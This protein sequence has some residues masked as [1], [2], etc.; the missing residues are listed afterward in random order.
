MLDG[1]RGGRLRV[2]ANV[3]VGYDNI[4]V[5]RRAPSTASS[6][7]NTPGVLDETTADLAFLLIL[8][9][10]RLA[11]R[12]RGRPARRPLAR[13]GGSR[14]T[15]AATCTARRSASSATAASARR[16]RGAPTGFGMRVLHH[17]R[18]RHRRCRATSPTSTSCSASAD[19]VSLHVPGGDATRH[20]IDARRLALMKPTAVLVNTARGPVVDE[21]ALADALA[22]RARCSRPGSTSS[23]ASPRCTRGCSPR[24]AHRAAAAHR[25]RHRWRPARAWPRSRA[26]ASSPCSRANART[27]PSQEV[28]MRQVVT[29]QT[30]SG[31]SVF[32]SDDQIEP[33]RLSLMPG[34]DS[35]GCGA[36]TRRRHCPPTARPRVRPPSSPR[37][38]LPLRLRHDPAQ[39][40]GDAARGPRRGGRLSP[41]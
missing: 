30:G 15:S 12:R 19:I 5:A 9:A 2:V 37:A 11:S 38:R 16:S 35:L 21:A 7:C 39:G 8:A 25:Q 24:A 10:S 28:E 13:A 20:L 23:S 22:R 3:A 33:I 6:V 29:G 4:D 36:V 34:L 41:R 32:V 17:A 18:D 26:K 27:I 31:K 14:S 1:R 40:V